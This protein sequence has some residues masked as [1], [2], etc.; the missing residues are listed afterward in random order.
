MACVS[1]AWTVVE[2]EGAGIPGEKGATG[3]AGAAGK[4]GA[5]GAAGKDGTDNRIIKAIYCNGALTGTS[6]FAVYEISILASG[7]LFAFGSISNLLD[8][9]G[10][11]AFYS[12][13]QVGAD[14]AAVIFTKDEFGSINGGWWDLS[15]DRGALVVTAKYNDTE[16]AQGST[17]YDMALGACTV[18]DF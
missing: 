6:L 12:V 17:S 9:S 10:A 18:H 13:N 5:A 16:L 3:E 15:M 1:S 7:D 2:V 14:T 11:S 8:E 4:D